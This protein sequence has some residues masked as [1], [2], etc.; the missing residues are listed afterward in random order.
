MSVHCGYCYKRGHNKLGC[1]E[2]KSDAKARPDS[3]LAREVAREQAEFKHRAKNRSC[4]YCGHGGHNRRGCSVKK[5]DIRQSEELA[6]LYRKKLAKVFQKEGIQLGSLLEVPYNKQMY[7]EDKVVTGKFIHIIERIDWGNMTH[8]LGGPGLG[9]IYK[10]NWRLDNTGT[11]DNVIHTRI[12]G[13][14]FNCSMEELKIHDHWLVNGLKPMGRSSVSVTSFLNKEMVPSLFDPNFQAD[15][16]RG[17][18]GT[19]AVPHVWSQTKFNIIPVSEADQFRSKV[20]ARGKDFT[21]YD[22][23]PK[24]LPHSFR[25]DAN[26][27][28]GHQR[29]SYGCEE[30]QK[31]ISD[32]KKEINH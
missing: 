14:D 26:I 11:D 21:D 15:L 25:Y 10:R 6:F 24:S 9:A 12:V 28:E 2:R 30:V 1:P 29:L 19:N 8:R 7:R 16:A 20:I 32:F 22:S 17:F 23:L 3:Y 13:W 4:T 31:N 18:G 27:V 5:A